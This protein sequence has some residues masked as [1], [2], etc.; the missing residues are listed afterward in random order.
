MYKVAFISGNSEGVQQSLNRT[1]SE[2]NIIK[3]EII[4]IVQSQSTGQSGVVLVS[5]TILYRK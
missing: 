1:I 2:I 3:G 4:Q 5:I